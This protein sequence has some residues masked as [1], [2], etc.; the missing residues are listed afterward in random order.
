MSTLQAQS[1][2]RIQNLL[3]NIENDVQKILLELK[4]FNPLRKS[5]RWGSIFVAGLANLTYGG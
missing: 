2:G 4:D 5:L 1:V 3:E